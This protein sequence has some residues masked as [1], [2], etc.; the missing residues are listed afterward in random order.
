[1]Y[2]QN[3]VKFRPFILKILRK[4]R[5]LMSIKGHNSFANLQKN[6]ALQSR[7]RPLIMRIQ[8][9]VKFCPFILKILNTNR[10]NDR[11]RE[12][13]GQGNSSIVQMTKLACRHHFP[14]ISLLDT[15]KHSRVANS[16]VSDLIMRKLKLLQDFIHTLNTCK[17]KK[18]WINSNQ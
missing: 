9:L 3:L 11:E 17:F 7:C 15:F 14:I 16:I 4:K 8:N 13:E 18:V 5:I 1:M 10:E 12:N 6:D 2:I